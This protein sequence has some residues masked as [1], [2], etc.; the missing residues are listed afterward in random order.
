MELDQYLNHFNH[1]RNGFDW[2]YTGSGPLQLSFAILAKTASVDIARTLMKEFSKEVVSQFKSKDWVLSTREVNEW[3]S[4]KNIITKKPNDLKRTGKSKPDNVVKTTCKELGITQ[5][6]LAAILEVPEGT[7]SSWAVK[8]D[9]P[10]LGKKA[11]E[12]YAEKIEAQNIV[13]KFKE[14]MDLVK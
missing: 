10:R 7:V 9:I 11:I 2:G 8:N 13:T 3:I 4:S 12:F 1:S 14:F 6:E 5:K